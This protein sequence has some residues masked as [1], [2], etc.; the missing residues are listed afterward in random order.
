MYIENKSPSNATV[1]IIENDGKK[2][3]N[4]FTKGLKTLGIADSRV[5]PSDVCCPED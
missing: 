5:L 4:T 3:Q 1:Q 2:I